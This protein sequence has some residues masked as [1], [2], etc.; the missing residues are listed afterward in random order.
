MRILFAGLFAISLFA[1]TSCSKQP[2]EDVSQAALAEILVGNW[3]VVSVKYTSEFGISAISYKSIQAVGSFTFTSDSTYHDV[4]FVYQFPVEGESVQV[5]DQVSQNGYY[6]LVENDEDL[7]EVNDRQSSSI[8]RYNTRLRTASSMIIIYE[9]KDVDLT[10]G[11]KSVDRY[12]FEVVK[13]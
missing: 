4:N 12:S 5:A 11:I 13:T 8:V 10:T 7:I 2:I 1:S 6:S 3:K 9:F